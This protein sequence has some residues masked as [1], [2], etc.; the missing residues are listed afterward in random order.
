M[1]HT[2]WKIVVNNEISPGFPNTT[3]VDIEGFTVA[4]H[5]HERQARRAIQAVNSYQAM[6]AFIND[7]L[8]QLDRQSNWF[9][10]CESID[11]DFRIKA[12]QALTLAEGKEPTS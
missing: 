9:G 10:D 5:L 6:R 12:R 1:N 3:I 4:E 11:D 7:F 2:P 8:E